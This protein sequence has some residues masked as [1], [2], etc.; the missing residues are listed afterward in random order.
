[1]KF[2]THYLELNERSNESLLD[3]RKPLPKDRKEKVL[4]YLKTGKPCGIRCAGI[5]DY[6]AGDETFITIYAFTDGEYRWCS[7]ETYH[8]EKYDIELDA[9]FISK[10]LSS[11]SETVLADDE[12]TD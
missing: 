8:F 5:Y 1:M 4:R 6:V 3:H 7:D 9:E 11:S 12:E 10:V 2:I